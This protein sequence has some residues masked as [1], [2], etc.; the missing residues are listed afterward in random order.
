MGGACSA[1]QAGSTDGGLT[2]V[3]PTSAAPLSK[4]VGQPAII[5]MT[6]GPK[7]INC[8]VSS[9]ESLLSDLD[10]LA[11]GD[12]GDPS[13]S[14]F[15]GLGQGGGVGI[16][17]DILKAMDPSLKAKLAALLTICNDSPSGDERNSASTAL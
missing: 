8:I 9:H 1:Q 5:P 11:T 12:P 16:K 7:N 13:L 17:E 3:V 15:S 14:S 4:A 2:N 10:T 6:P